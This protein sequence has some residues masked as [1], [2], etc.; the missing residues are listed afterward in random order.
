MLL[1]NSIV[2]KWYH[3]LDDQSVCSVCSLRVKFNIDFSF[4][5]M[6][7][8]YSINFKKSIKKSRK[9]SWKEIQGT[10]QG[11]F[12]LDSVVQVIILGY[13]LKKGNRQLMAKVSLSQTRQS[14]LSEQYASQLYRNAQV[15]QDINVLFVWSKKGAIP[16]N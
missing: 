11:T 5:G 4:S 8:L 10:Y 2:I 7:K 13:S 14:H 12:S 9:N 16:K 6:G 1:Y 15:N 3:S